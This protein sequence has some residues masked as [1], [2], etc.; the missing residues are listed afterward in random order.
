MKIW[1]RESGNF[2]D[3]NDPTQ[4]WRGPS[5]KRL[6]ISTNDLYCQKLESSAYIFVAAC[7]GL[8]SFTFVQWPPQNASFLHQ[9][10]FWPFKVVQGHPR[11][12]IGTGTS[13][14]NKGYMNYSLLFLIPFVP[15]ELLLSYP[16]VEHRRPSFTSAI[17]SLIDRLGLPI[18]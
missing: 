10:A 6:R 11:F 3:F 16:E 13:T 17:V 18:G 2:V 5:K 4:V 7:M 1:Q 8:S 12:T 9:S 14:C 15:L